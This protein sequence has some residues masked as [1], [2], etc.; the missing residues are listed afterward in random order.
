MKVS[1]TSC[2]TPSRTSRPAAFHTL[3]PHNTVQG[4]ISDLHSSLATEPES[5]PRRETA[6]NVHFVDQKYWGQLNR[7]NFKRDKSCIVGIKKGCCSTKNSPNEHFKALHENK[8]MR[9]FLAG[10]VNNDEDDLPSP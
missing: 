8:N 10:I 4:L 2:S 7:N 6:L 5:G 9:H 3:S 1:K